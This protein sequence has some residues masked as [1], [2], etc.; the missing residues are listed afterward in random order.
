M[1]AAKYAHEGNGNE[2]T[3]LKVY[4]TV[5]PRTSYKLQNRVETDPIM[6]MFCRYTREGKMLKDSCQVRKY[7][8][9]QEPERSI[10][11]LQT[12]HLIIHR[13]VL[14]LHRR[15]GPVGPSTNHKAGIGEGTED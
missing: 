3:L 14:P 10:L 13:H 8:Q 6:L 1:P 5:T 7:T 15:G 4:S 2:S 9:K 11:R 12:T